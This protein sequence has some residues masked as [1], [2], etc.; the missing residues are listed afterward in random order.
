[1]Y[2]RPALESA[3]ASPNFC[4]IALRAQV[5]VTGP[6]PGLSIQKNVNRVY[7]EVYRDNPVKYS[8]VSGVPYDL[9]AQ[10]ATNTLEVLLVADPEGAA[11]VYSYGPFD[12]S[13]VLAGK[14][15]GTDISQRKIGERNAVEG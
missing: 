2:R 14:V 5:S 12:V 11:Q 6:P 15:G 3:N 13:G 9:V 10:V 7:S 1:M 4:R 8:P